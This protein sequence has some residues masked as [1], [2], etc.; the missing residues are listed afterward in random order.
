MR[1]I[2]LLL[3][4][5]LILAAPPAEARKPNTRCYCMPAPFATR[6]T[7]ADA[8]F[9]GEA[10]EVETQEPMV[11]YGNDDIPVKVTFKIDKAYKGANDGNTFLIYSNMHVWTCAGATFEKGKKYLVYAYKRRPE[12]YETWSIYQFPSETYDVGGACGGIAL[13][14]AKEAAD[15]LMLLKDKPVDNTTQSP[16]INGVIGAIPEKNAPKPEGAA[17]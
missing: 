13:Q 3:L 8:V 14:D 6:Y 12:H 16:I 1:A 15:D 9:T 7:T 5:A 11:E 17:E 10:T 4:A 2:A